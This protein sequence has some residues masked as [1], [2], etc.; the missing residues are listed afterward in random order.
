MAPRMDDVMRLCCEISA[1]DQIKVAVKNSTKGAVVAGGSAFVG[2]LLAGPPG[3]AVGGAVG[4]LLGSWLTSGQFKPLPQ[5]LME[6][7]PN[8][9]KKLYTDIMAVLGNLNWM[10]AAQLIALVMGNATLQQQVTAA[11]LNYV[12]KELRAEVRYQDSKLK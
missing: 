10:D 9:Q 11:L 2:G 6:L 4:G 3:I 12:S 1:H 5:I 8:E 7:P